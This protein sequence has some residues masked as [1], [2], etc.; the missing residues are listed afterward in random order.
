MLAIYEA[1]GI[2]RE[3]NER[4][5]GWQSSIETQFNVMRRLADW[6]Y[7]HAT[8]WAE[9]LAVH[10]QWV[11]DFNDQDHWAHRERE[12]D[13]RSPA[14]PGWVRGRA[15]EP[16][17]LHR[18]FCAA[19]FGRR[20]DRRGYA[21]FRHWRLHSEAG[22]TGEPIAVWLYG[23]HLTV[24]Y[25]DE[26]LSHSTV[27]YQPDGRHLLTVERPVLF[28]TAYHS[29][30]LA[31]WALDDDKWRKALPVA[32][33]IRRRARSRAEPAVQ[34]ALFAWQPGRRPGRSREPLV[35]R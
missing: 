4:R 19:R 8:S 10:D 16:A 13:K 1:L 33:V 34:A 24:E 9:L 2:R 5:Q 22:L 17:D 3:Q 11:V 18:I 30:R 12:D 26:I 27:T 23:E 7:A 31:L 6:H 28:E 20:V 14:P 25:A 32:L 35:G 29:P 15:V 21:R